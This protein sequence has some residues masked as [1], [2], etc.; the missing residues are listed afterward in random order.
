[1]IYCF[2]LQ[3]YLLTLSSSALKDM[4]KTALVNQ[5]KILVEFEGEDSP[6]AK[7]LKDELKTVEKIDADKSDRQFDRAGGL[8][9][10]LAG[11]AAPE[12]STEK[13]EEKKPSGDKEP[14]KEKER[15]HK[16]AKK[17]S[18]TAA[19]PVVAKAE[20]PVP[21][22]AAPSRAKAAIVD[23]DGEL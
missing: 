12:P 20:A 23:D 6:L 10:A 11:T 2:A 14:K 4:W 19:L 22:P 7:A 5:R 16:E 9:A 18:S 21:A 17:E 1:L 8:T 15:E 3:D 13:K